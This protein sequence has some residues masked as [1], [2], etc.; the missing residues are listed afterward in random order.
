MHQF[1][2]ESLFQLVMAFQE[3]LSLLPQHGIVMSTNICCELVG[4]VQVIVKL[5]ILSVLDHDLLIQV[6][7]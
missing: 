7:Y 5:L 1:A 3:V 4:L 6:S 2:F